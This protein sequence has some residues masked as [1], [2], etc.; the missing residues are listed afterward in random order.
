MD[1][2]PELPQRIQESLREDTIVVVHGLRGTGKTKAMQ[3][4]ADTLRQQDPDATVVLISK[5]NY[6]FRHIRQH[7][8]LLDHL[9][10]H[11][12]KKSRRYLFV[13][14]IQ[15]IERVRVALKS[16]T[17]IGSWSVC[18][19]CSN[20]DWINEGADTTFRDRLTLIPVHPLS[21][22][23]FIRYHGWGNVPEALVRFIRHGG[24]PHLRMLPGN[25]VAVYRHLRHHQDVII[26]NDIVGCH[27]IRNVHFLMELLLYLAETTGFI[28]TS[29][30]I[31]DYLRTQGV[32]LSPR[33]VLE[34]LTFLE[35]SHYIRRIRRID[36]ISRKKYDIGEAFY[37]TDL[38]LRH[39]L[40][41]FRQEEVLQ[42][43][44]NLICNQLASAGWTVYTGTV[45][46]A[47]VG[48]VADRDGVRQYI[49]V[50]YVLENPTERELKIGTLERFEPGAPKTIVSMDKKY[51]L[52]HPDIRH[53]HIR[54]YLS[55]S[56]G[57]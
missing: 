24:M 33:V 51:R 43:L 12:D 34:Y 35:V 6:A 3:Q 7:T 46:E 18:C 27:K 54:E 10:T 9:K 19:T 31:S 49:Q 41:P 37:F 26:L 4:V 21:Y 15:S 5:D 29:K 32:N 28:L 22:N 45:D 2:R 48:L 17:R 16:L 42:V 52:D 44:E 36:P 30:R 11:Q 50:A 39:V 14:E 25:D 55:G 57:E 13:D 1:L 56:L 47:K 40:R 20:L 53:V 38:G 23:E 8:D